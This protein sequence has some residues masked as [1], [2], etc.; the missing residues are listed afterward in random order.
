MAVGWSSLILI[1][2]FVVVVVDDVIVGF[3]RV[4]SVRVSVI[5]SARVLFVIVV[6][7]NN[8]ERNQAQATNNLTHY[9][10]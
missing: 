1:I 6:T 9:Y 8:E 4:L 3:V 5:V 7:T 2:R 10:Y